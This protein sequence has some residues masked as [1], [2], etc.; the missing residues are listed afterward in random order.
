MVGFTTQ[1][2]QAFVVC[3]YVRVKQATRHALRCL[4]HQ[5]AAFAPYLET[6]TAN[7]YT[8]RKTAQLAQSHF[9]HLGA[10]AEYAF[11]EF[12]HWPW[13]AIIAHH[14]QS[15]ALSPCASTQSTLPESDRCF[16]SAARLVH[17]RLQHPKNGLT[18]P[19]ACLLG[20]AT[21]WPADSCPTWE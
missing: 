15:S 20:M 8:Q 21:W 14:K 4:A 6:H 16:I 13:H 2:L 5:S 10:S 17:S 12:S 9:I 1:Q 11:T 18:P 3:V 19:G 7:E